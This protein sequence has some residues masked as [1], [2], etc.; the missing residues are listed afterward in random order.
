MAVPVSMYMKFSEEVKKRTDAP[1]VFMKS[2]QTMSHR[3]FKIQ[4]SHYVALASQFFKLS[5]YLDSLKNCDTKPFDKKLAI[6]G[7][8]LYPH[9]RYL[10]ST[11]WQ[12]LLLR[13]ATMQDVSI[14]TSESLYLHIYFLIFQLNREKNG[15]QT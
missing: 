6:A 15:F 1:L 10:Q 9:F 4:G 2:L 13:R 8:V 11:N 5:Q 12:L 3:C 7:Q 14:F